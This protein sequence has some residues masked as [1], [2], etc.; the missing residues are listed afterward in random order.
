VIRKR[1]WSL[2]SA[3]AITASAGFLVHP[4][5]GVASTTNCPLDEARAWVE[6]NADRLP[7]TLAEIERHAPA[8][9]KA[10]LAKLTPGARAAVW[11]E[12]FAAIAADTTAYLS[13]SQLAELEF[14]GSRL[15]S[16]FVSIASGNRQE[17][18]ALVDRIQKQFDR[19]MIARLFMSTGFAALTA[20]SC[21][22]SH[23]WND[24]A[25]GSDC[26]R[27]MDPTGACS[28]T[29]SGC[30]FFDAYACD[31]VCDDRAS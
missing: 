20:A 29:S 9:R 4:G 12:H 27:Q 5:S 18:Q 19:P 21:T 17:L 24:C 2:L 31:G 13:N 15:E 3:A 23:E 28:P 6:D 16:V 14:I 30:G 25:V 10:I 11:R 8:F 1:A 7:S 22:C 26:E